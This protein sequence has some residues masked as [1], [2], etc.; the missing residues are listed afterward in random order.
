[1]KKIKNFENFDNKQFDEQFELIG[2]DVDEILDAINFINND[3]AELAISLSVSW[4]PFI[5]II[6]LEKTYLN[7]GECSILVKFEPE[8]DENL[9]IRH[10][11]DF[12]NK[13]EFKCK[14][15]KTK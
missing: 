4:D 12:L 7:S 15:Y 11:N 14:L 10:I 8:G 6:P 5:K 2:P 1:M 9:H 3:Y 13:N